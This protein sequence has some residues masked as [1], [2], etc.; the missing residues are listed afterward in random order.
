MVGRGY[1]QRRARISRRV[2]RRCSGVVSSSRLVISQQSSSFNTNYF[3][4]L[5]PP[6]REGLSAFRIELSVEQSNNQ[7][8]ITVVLDVK[9]M[10]A[11]STSKQNGV[12]PRFL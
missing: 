4:N 5:R 10:I 9:N 12:F 3:Y 8:V 11:T 1:H 2:L 7:V 6:V